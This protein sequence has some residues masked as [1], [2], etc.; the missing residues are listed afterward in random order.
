MTVMYD[1]RKGENRHRM[2][3]GGHGLIIL[4]Y[5]DLRV[6]NKYYLLP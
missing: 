5:A 4:G 1:K 2:T 6:G 3:G